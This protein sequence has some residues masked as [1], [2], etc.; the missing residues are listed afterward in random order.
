MSYLI[1]DFI[2]N[3]D[4]QRPSLQRILGD[5]GLGQN[6]GLME[7]G[8]VYRPRNASGNTTPIS[9]EFIESAR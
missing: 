4:F 6:D 8:G 2:E 9:L 3:F 5:K 1:I 7:T